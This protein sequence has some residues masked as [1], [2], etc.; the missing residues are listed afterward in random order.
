LGFA[1]NF[2]SDLRGPGIIVVERTD[3][4]AILA[5]ELESWRQRPFHE[6]SRM[7]GMPAAART[8]RLKGEDLSL[9][10]TVRWS[11]DRQRGVLIEVTADGPSTWKLERLEERID[12]KTPT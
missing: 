6:V 10:V 5:A 4:Y 12:I 3:A 7:V 1:K 8:V 2:Q 9:T 11:D